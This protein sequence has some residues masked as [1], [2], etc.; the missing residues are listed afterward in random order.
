MQPQLSSE[1]EED[2]EH[3]SEHQIIAEL[4]ELSLMSS[5]ESSYSDKDDDCESLPFSPIT[6][7]DAD[8][9][10]LDCVPVSTATS[11]T[12]SITC[13]DFN[14]ANEASIQSGTQPATPI[15]DYVLS[16]KIV[17]DN[18]DK[19]INPR[20]M[21][22]DRK[23]QSL[24]YFHSYAVKD[25]ISLAGFDYEVA[26]SCLPSPDQVAKS[27]LPT[28]IDDDVIV[29]NLKILFSRVLFETLPFFNTSFSGLVVN[30]ITHRRS[31]EMSKKSLVVS[32]D[33]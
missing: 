1:S 16:F 10:Y 27:L 33:I 29:S 3:Q 26:P 5:S 32:T 23:S 30:T 13:M 31:E 17:G 19:S 6:D 18:I 7:S 14:L 15:Q 21:R 28:P 24:H 22:S 9:D 20:Y 12:C 25:R 2:D 8:F 4:T 11:H